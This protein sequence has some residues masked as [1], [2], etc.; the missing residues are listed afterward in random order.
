MKYPSVSLIAIGLVLV[1][2]LVTEI[3]VGFAATSAAS[4]NTPLVITVPAGDVPALYR[5]VYEESGEPRDNVRIML[6]PGVFLLDPSQHFGGR[7]LLGKKTILQS[8]LAMAVDANGVPVIDANGAP[9]VLVQGA[10]IDSTQVASTFFGMGIIEVGEQ[11]AVEQLW[12]D[13]GSDPFAALA[14]G[15]EIVSQGAVRGV[16]S[17]GHFIGIRVR[18]KSMVA[19]GKV[20]T[21]FLGGNAVGISV[22]GIEPTT[23]HPTGNDAKVE[24]AL[25]HNAV[26]NNSLANLNVIGGFG[27]DRNKVKVVANGNIFRGGSANASVRVI[28][29]SD[30]FTRG[31]NNCDVD[32][33]LADNLIADTGVGLEISG[34]MLFIANDSI[35]LEERYSSNNEAKVRI[36][37]TT[38]GNNAKDIVASGAR[39]N[40]G[41]PAGGHNNKAKVVVQENDPL[42]LTAEVHDCYPENDTMA[43][44]NEAK[45]TG[46]NITLDN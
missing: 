37:N 15:I 6:E 31:S 38:F 14:S 3:K 32:L 10:R 36:S 13:G 30:F 22:I 41:E 40:T 20:D 35:P 45:V 43:C 26:I 29:G 19:Q 33:T 7:L 8:T 27:S 18:A 16:Y 1:V 44:N 9:V 46:G 21:S 11:G 34:G 23:D 5:A 24:V 12:V 25:D 39:S 2:A 4:D 28:A 17:T 42:P